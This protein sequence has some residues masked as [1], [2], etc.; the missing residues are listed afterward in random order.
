MLMPDAGNFSS[1]A[2]GEMGVNSR[3]AA[4]E[5]AMAVL[6]CA[7]EVR[8]RVAGEGGG[9]AA[10]SRR[11]RAVADPLNALQTSNSTAIPS[12]WGCRAINDVATTVSRF[13]PFP[14]SPSTTPL[15]PADRRNTHSLRRKYSRIAKVAKT[16]VNS[17]RGAR[18]FRRKRTPTKFSFRLFPTASPAPPH[19]RHIQQQR[20]HGFAYRVKRRRYQGGVVWSACAF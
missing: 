13:L 20:P 6:A 12:L 19:R 9:G 2:R 8:E 15:N 7:G 5:T 18:K 11:S 16:K 3:T 14:S 4:G 17:P 1:N 10:L